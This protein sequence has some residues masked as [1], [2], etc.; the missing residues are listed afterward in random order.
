LYIFWFAKEGDG[1]GFITRYPP[2]K[3]FFICVSKT[4]VFLSTVRGRYSTEHHS[5]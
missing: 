5:N 3:A 1:K 4:V 2:K